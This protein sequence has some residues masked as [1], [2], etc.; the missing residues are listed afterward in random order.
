MN[1]TLIIPARYGSTRFPGKPLASIAGKPMI[2][3]VYERASL[4]KGLA[5]IVVAT[6]DERIQAVVEGFGGKVVMTNPDAATG[7]DRINEAIAK[8]GLPDDEIIINLQGDQPLV[9]PISIE[10]LITLFEKH[11]GEFEMA[12]LAYQITN[13][14]DI[15]D[16][17][18]VKVVFDNQH[19]ALY[20]SRSRIPFGRDTNEYPVFKHIG[21]YA[22]TSRFIQMF[23]KLP[24]GT[25]EQLEKLEQLRALEHGH[26]IK[27][28]ISAFN[29]QEV[30]T[31]ED[32]KKCEARLAID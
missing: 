18:Q 25:L 20:F 29:S 26:K 15:D 6:D 17:M 21:M 16:P 12:T 1:F 23:A 3:H 9:D 19:H 31:P 13:E 30:D 8:L 14:K 4:A 11:P 7:T 2:Q 32:V 27:I 22:Y 10:Q 24:H 28:A 5:N